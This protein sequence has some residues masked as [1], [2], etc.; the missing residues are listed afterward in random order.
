MMIYN[1]YSE[2]ARIMDQ[3]ILY[4]VQNNQ[5]NDES[6]FLLKYRNNITSQDG[7]DGIIEKIFD[8]IGNQNKWFVEFG[9]YDGLENCNSHTLATQKDWQGVFIEGDHSRYCLLEKTYNDHEGTHLVHTFVG[10]G[11]GQMPLDTILSDYDIPHDFDLVSID[12]DGNDW[13]VW[14]GLT[15]YRPRIVIIEFNP[16]IS[17]DIVFIQ[18]NV[19]MVQQGNSLLA[20]IQ[21]GKE[22]GYELICVT[23]YNAFFVVKEEYAAFKIDDNS[24]EAMHMPMMDGRVFHCYDATIYNT[25]MP[26]LI[27]AVSGQP[28]D[29]GFIGIKEIKLVRG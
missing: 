27:W 21:L 26:K 28:H 13:H 8:L 15:N 16:T 5:L 6:R 10:E 2:Y 18:Q 7:E 22:K 19:K 4:K 12:I 3:P 1:Y 11:A 20:F 25:G 17:N 29:T 24:I 9:A 23:Q 14:K